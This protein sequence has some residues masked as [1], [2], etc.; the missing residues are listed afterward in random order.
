[1]NNR[2][3]PFLLGLAFGHF[4]LRWFI[5]AAYIV[6]IVAAFYLGRFSA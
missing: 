6:S 4:G 3:V 1:M 5:H 2:A